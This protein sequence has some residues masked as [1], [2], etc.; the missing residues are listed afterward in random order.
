MAFNDPHRIEQEDVSLAD[1]FSPITFD[2][3]TQQGNGWILIEWALRL[4]VVVDIVDGTE[5]IKVEY[6]MTENDGIADRVDSLGN[7]AAG[8]HE[9]I[10]GSNVEPYG[11]FRVQGEN[12]TSSF[13]LFGT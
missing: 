4:S 1:S 9:I 10:T 11:Y 13:Y 2:G 5:N 12:G 8:R 7:V 6:K 3:V